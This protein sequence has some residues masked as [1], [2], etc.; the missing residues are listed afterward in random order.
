MWALAERV[1]LDL[2]SPYAYIMWSDHHATTSLVAVHDDDVVGFVLGFCLPAEPDTL[3]VWQ[4]GVD[5]R[6]RGEGIAGQML[7]VLVTRVAPTVVE[8]TVT[9]DNA[10]STALFR[11]LGARHG[12]TV[13]QS[14]A[15]EEDLFPAGHA[16]EIRLRIPVRTG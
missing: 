5:E 8:A 6:V 16:A 7:D 4:I 11:A 9:P 1:G 3:F 12:T 2:N 14:A 10:A 13:I 15:Y